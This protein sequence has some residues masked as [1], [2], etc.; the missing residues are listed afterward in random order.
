[1]RIRDRDRI[2]AFLRRDTALHL[3]ALADLDEPF[4]RRTEWFVRESDGEIV[5]LAMLFHGLDPPVLYAVCRPGHDGTRRL[6]RDLEPDLP[7]RVFADVGIGVEAALER[8]DGGI[9]RRYVKMLLRDRAG[10]G[11][12]DTSSCERLRTEHAD[13]LAA[14]LTG[15][16]Y[17]PG[18]EDG[19]FFDPV[20]LEIGPYFAIRDR[21]DI[22]AAGGVH[23]RSPRYGVAALGNIATRP[24]RRGRGYATCITAALC[25][26]LEA[27]IPW[28]GLNV[29]ADNRAATRCYE[30]LGFDRVCPYLEQPFARLSL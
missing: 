14:F 26:E 8:W 24:D 13:E 6:V 23:V 25:R 30:R 4:W 7:D 27:T 12:I 2:E 22:V 19:R 10:P 16:A 17:A 9:C 5:A 28:I 3:Y 11:A 20:L 21:G 18:E 15:P 29:E 1:M